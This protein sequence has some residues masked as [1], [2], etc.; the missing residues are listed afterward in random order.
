LFCRIEK[1]VPASAIAAGTGFFID[2]CLTIS[3]LLFLF[4]RGGAFNEK[5]VDMRDRVNRK[6]LVFIFIVFAYITG[7]CVNAS[8]V[9]IAEEQIRYME[10]VEQ[11]LQDMEDIEDVMFD[12]I[13]GEDEMRQILA[14]TVT[15]PIAKKKGAPK[16][17]PAPVVRPPV[18]K[19]PVQIVKSPETPVQPPPVKK[20]MIKEIS[21]KEVKKPVPVSVEVPQEPAVKKEVSKEEPVKK[22]SIPKSPQK[23][24]LVQAALA[25]K[26][27][28]LPAVP[29]LP[30]PV[31]GKEVPKE[32]PVKKEFVPKS[33]QKKELVRVALAPKEAVLPAVPVLPEPVAG[34]EVPK[35]E[36]VKKEPVQKTPEKKETVQIAM[37]PQAPAPRNASSGIP[38]KRKAITLQELKKRLNLTDKQMS[39][40]RPIMQEKI[41]KRKEI[42][43]KYAGKGEA[44][45]ASLKQEFQLFQ[46]YYDDMYEHLLTEVQWQQYQ[47]MRRELK[48]PTAG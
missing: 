1:P 4:L 32:E 19:K 3:I 47:E 16:K 42:I 38:A 45:M 27:A 29:V 24:E 23:K 20:E 46:K 37:V 8:A 33:P 22:V 2:F 9:D 15:P 28:V 36:P 48:A 14:E 13:P 40:I 41:D 12:D 7:T 43:K 34:K 44:A 25:P 30:E 17:K 18:E 5:E 6:E 21:Q 31:I 10:S 26:E 11:P 39:R 35:E